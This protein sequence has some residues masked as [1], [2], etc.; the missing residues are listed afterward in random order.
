MRTS[1]C[2]PVALSSLAASTPLVA[3]QAPH[4]PPLSSGNGFTLV[5]NETG[6]VV[7]TA[8]TGAGSSLAVLSDPSSIPGRVFYL[9]GTAEDWR[10]SRTHVLTDGGTPPFPFGLGI[11]DPSGDVPLNISSVVVNAGSGTPAKLANFPEPVPAL[12]NV[13]GWGSWVAC[14]RYVR[15]ANAVLTVLGYV[16]AKNGE[17]HPEIPEG[18]AKVTLLPQCAQLPELPEGSI[19]SHEFALEVKCYE[20]VVDADW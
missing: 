12:V 11:V 9:N 20:N 10:Y 18:C 15:P 5:A 16:Y 1:A 2:L 13:L 19:S 14:D 17:V 6:R 3:R 7:S 4:Y 8:H